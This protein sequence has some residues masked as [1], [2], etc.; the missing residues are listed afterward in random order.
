MEINFEQIPH[1]LMHHFLRG[2]FDGDGSICH[3]IQDGKIRWQVSFIGTIHFLNYVQKFLNKKHELSTCGNN[4]RFNF[5]KFCDVKDILNILYKDAT[6]FLDRKYEK[7]KEF[8]ALNDYQA[9]S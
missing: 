6:I 8:F 2:Y 1:E 9:A 7:V 4:Y 5:S 3:T